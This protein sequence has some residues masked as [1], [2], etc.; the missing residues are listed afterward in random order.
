MA[1]KRPALQ[2]T[3]HLSDTIVFVRKHT[4]DEWCQVF[5]CHRKITSRNCCHQLFVRRHGRIHQTK[6]KEQ[7]ALIEKCS[8]VKRSQGWDFS[9]TPLLPRFHPTPVRTKDMPIYNIN[10]PSIFLR[11]QETLDVS[12]MKTQIIRTRGASGPCIW[13]DVW[14]MLRM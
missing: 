7:R 9:H 4:R 6:V 10:D 14:I 5:S 13:N 11:H 12:S 8:Q 3:V 2:S 1:R